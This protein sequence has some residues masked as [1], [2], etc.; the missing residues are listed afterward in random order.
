[1]W[2]DRMPRDGE[3]V[4]RSLQQ[5]ALEL[6]GER[7]RDLDVRVPVPPATEVVM[8]VLLL[9]PS[10]RRYS[11]GIGRASAG[12]DHPSPAIPHRTTDRV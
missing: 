2:F 3:K 4:R 8:P 10:L 9:G 7:G 5:A 1:M 11:K 6:F 12:G